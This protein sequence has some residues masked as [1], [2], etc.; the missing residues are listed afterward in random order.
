MDIIMLALPRWDGPYSSTAFS[1]ARELS[2][3]DRVFY[4]DNP[5]TLKDLAWGM[6]SSRMRGRMKSLLL[7]KSA[8]ADTNDSYRQLVCVTPPP[9]L[10]VNFLPPGFGYDMISSFND[11][12]FFDAMRRLMERFSITEFIYVNVYNPFYGRKFPEWFKPRAFVYY[13]VDN[14]ARS[15]YVCK[16]G[17]RLEATM[18]RRADMT[19]TTSRELWSK[20][21]KFTSNAYYL[22]NAADIG[23]FMRKLPINIERP[24]ELRQVNTPIVIYT[25]HID[26]RLDYSLVRAIL[27]RHIDKTLVMVGP[28]SISRELYEDLKAYPNML[29]VGGRALSEL[30]AYLSHSQCAIIPFKCDE[31]TRSIY[32]LKVNEYLA[33]GLP[34]VS[35]SFSED[36][37][38]FANVVEIGDSETDF[39]DRISVAICNDHEESR[40]S[41]IRVASCNNWES[42]ARRFWEIVGR[43]I[44]NSAKNK[45][46]RLL[47]GLAFSHW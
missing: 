23:L 17:P 20:A 37:R 34:V 16:H 21:R 39:C 31:L 45:N 6:N 4:I 32:P 47:R 29:F 9:A 19:L 11:Y 24:A 28:R 43:N 46:H 1:M 44:G 8:I 38:S 27:A 14:I 41:R 15:K 3:K 42:R 5:F 18:I 35:T 12:V 13:S 7:W 30:P 25:G 40:N 22:P 10:P 36:I 26:V 33:A 2:K